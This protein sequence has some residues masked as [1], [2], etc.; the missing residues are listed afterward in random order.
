MKTV[1]VAKLEAREEQEHQ[2]RVQAA[3]KGKLGS[4]K[5]REKKPAKKA[6]KK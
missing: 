6:K 2:A 4:S 1:R 3:L 5:P